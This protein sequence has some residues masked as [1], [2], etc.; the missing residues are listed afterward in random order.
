MIIGANYIVCIANMYALIRSKLASILLTLHLVKKKR[1]QFKLIY[2]IQKALQMSHDQ[3][4]FILR[5]KVSLV[6][7]VISEFKEEP[8]LALFRLVYF[9]L[10][11]C[12]SEILGTF[13]CNLHLLI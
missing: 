1:L 10:S 13:V 7:S 12:F 8:L 3:N 6:S 4:L 9:N 2:L 11:A 5:D